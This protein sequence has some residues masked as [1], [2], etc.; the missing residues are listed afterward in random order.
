MKMDTLVIECLC[1][2]KV[3]LSLAQQFISESSSVP[4][5]AVGKNIET[6]NLHKHI[7]LKGII[8]DYCNPGDNWNGIALLH[9]TD[10]AKDALIANCST[11]VSPVNVVNNF[12]TAGF[13]RL[14]SLNSLIEAS[15]GELPWPRFVL[16]ARKDIHE[17]SEQWQAI[18]DS[19]AD[20]E[21]RI[22]FQNVI[23]YRLTAS[24]ESMMSY[25][26]RLDQQ[27]LEDFMQYSHEIFVDAGGFDGDTS[28][29]FAEIY[30]DYKKILFFEPSATNLANARKR[31]KNARDIE[32]FQKGLSDKQ[33]RLPFNAEAG[34]S[35][36]ISQEGTELISLDRLD[37]LTEDPVTFIKMDVEGWELKALA[38]AEKLIRENKPKL[39]IAVYHDSADF[40]LIF[41]HIRQLHDDYQVFLRHYTQGWSET[42]MYFLPED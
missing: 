33:E 25:T 26:V 35:S 1:P 3:D 19:L 41:D 9:S 36:A 7:P 24:L 8:D 16:S 17:H 38:G 42:I 6:L 34:S 23:R 30:G 22:T 31:L 18:Y 5:Y 15:Q 10:A 27:Y 20:E 29:A 11:S 13:T 12:R 28:E 2:L 39:A 32:Y 4:R 37:A 14:V 40:R 21:S